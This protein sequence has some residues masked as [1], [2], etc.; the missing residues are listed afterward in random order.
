MI[1][2]EIELKSFVGAK[3]DNPHSLLGM[4][5]AKGG[6]VVRA[7]LLNAQAAELIDLRNEAKARYPMEKLDNSGFF[8]LFLP[9]Q[10]ECFNYRIRIKSYNGQV[11]QIY[12][13]YSFK[14]S[15]S[16]DDLYLIG[17]G[18]QHKIYEKLGSHL[19]KIDGISGVRFAV[20]APNAR[21]IS[22]V[23]DFNESDGRYHQMRKLGSTG[24]WEIFIPALK[25][26]T[27]YKYEILPQVGDLPFLKTDPYALSYD[28]QPFNNSIVCDISNYQWKD[29]KW[30]QKRQNTNHKTAP[31][32][33][34]EVHLGSWMRNAKDGNRVLTYKEIAPLLAS[35]C[36]KMNFTHVELMPVTEYPFEGSWGYQVTGF[37]APTFRYGTPQDFMYFVDYLHQEGIGIILDWVPS[38]FPKDSFALARFDGTCLYEHEDSRL[39]EHKEWGTLCFNYSRSEVKNFLIGSALSM[40]DRFHVDGLRVD[41]VAS[42][43]Y[44]DYGREEGE[45][46]P[47][48]YGNNINIGAIDFLKALNSIVHT[49]HKGVLTIAEES[50]AFLGLTNTVEDGG[51]GFDFKW[52]MGWM[53]DTLSFL[54]EDP[55]NRKYHHNRITF[56]AIYQFSESFVSVYSHDEVV[57]GKSSMINKMGSGYWT[58]KAATLRALY[59]YMWMWSGKK[60]L[61]MGCE[62]GQSSEWKY[63]ASLDWNLLEYKD[64]AGISAALRDISG[65][66]IN[67]EKLAE[68]DLEWDCFKWITCDDRDAS[69]IAFLRYSKDKKTAYATVCNFTP[70]QRD[71]YPIGLPFEGEWTEIFNSDSSAYGGNN[72]GN[73]GSIIAERADY[74]DF[75][76][77]AKVTIPSLSTVVFKKS[78]GA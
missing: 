49:Y 33:I 43:L 67:D 16:E 14:P 37:F 71:G 38:H 41:A 74:G 12:D 25:V 21:R 29:D 40:I 65:I 69:V 68:G 24:I 42:M 48:E 72:N 9:Q 50:T 70:M 35:Y 32:A 66:Y 20:W 2:S 45:W 46:L 3:N 22:V 54:K 51:I 26:G 76:Y 34:Y 78:F 64:H 75:L 8:E 60:T 77:T 47:N 44:L 53:H 10:K 27:K 63:D 52:N 59:G 55:I 58:D 18:D 11:A 5:K 62:F 28:P 4:H 31:M 36:K 6:L 56:P 15:L 30:L 39:G 13:P 17:K 57:H 73:G 61:F 1:I 23:G 7:Y 19:H